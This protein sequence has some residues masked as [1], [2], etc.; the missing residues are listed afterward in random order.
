ML[1][2]LATPMKGAA[3][4]IV[5]DVNNHRLAMASKLGA[6]VII[7]GSETD[8]L[9]VICAETG[10]KGAGAVIEAVGVS[11]TANQSV[12]AV[13]NGGVVTWI[14]NSAPEVTINM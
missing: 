9:S 1:T 11:E 13:R 14:G 12:F 4:I 8:P 6:D 2:I 7:N 5:S 10:G 3:K